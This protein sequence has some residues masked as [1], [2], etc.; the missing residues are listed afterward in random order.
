M[1]KAYPLATFLGLLFLCSC[2]TEPPSSRDNAQSKLPPEISINENAGRGGW[3][4]VTLHNDTGNA[5]PFLL[6]TG[7][8]GTLF[9]KSV[10]SKLGKSLG[11][12]SVVGWGQKNAGHIYA[13]PRL[14]L[15]DVPL[16]TPSETA[17]Y[18][19]GTLRDGTGTRVDG[20][21]GYDTLRH[22]CIQLDF[23]ARKMR[24]LDDNTAD[25]STW[26]KAFPI[27]DLNVDDERPSVEQNLLGQH[28]PHSL[29]DTGSNND[30]WL[31]TRNYRQWTNGVPIKGQ[32]KK[33]YG[34]F[35][36]TRYPSVSLGAANVESDGIGIRFL[37]RH[38]VTFDF[39]KRKLYLKLQ[40]LSPLPKS[41]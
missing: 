14:Y 8:S 36:G 22:Y 1:L 18:D 20:I 30:G 3:V 35:D 25:K 15:G 21:I 26:G 10:E 24:F 2:A 41:E 34:L 37:A 6:D 38:L 29:I 5:F 32:V 39:P 9:D 33:P 17:T 16:R 40:T 11:D 23:V 19:L 13:M 12:V 27:R 31:M 4:V 28:G 7:T